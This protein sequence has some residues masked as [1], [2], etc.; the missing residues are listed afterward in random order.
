MNTLTLDLTLMELACVCQV[1]I[2]TFSE[3]DC[4]ILL[5]PH[6]PFRAASFKY[7]KSLRPKNDKAIITYD[8]LTEIRQKLHCSPNQGVKGYQNVVSEDENR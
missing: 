4:N 2:K 5:W 7:S 8:N 1:A 3:E 6:L